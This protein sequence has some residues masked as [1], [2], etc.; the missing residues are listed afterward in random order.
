M[1]LKMRVIRSPRRKTSQLTMEP[2]GVLTVRVPSWMPDEEVRRLVAKNRQ[3]I[4]EKQAEVAKKRD[5]QIRITDQM[6]RDGVEKAL[7]II[8]ERVAFYARQMG[9]EGRYHR[10][11]IREQKTRWG[12]CSSQGNLN[13]N[14]KLVLMPQEVLDYV[15]VHEL[16]HLYEMNHSPRFWSVVERVL[17][18]YKRRRDLLGQWGTRLQ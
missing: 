14:W 7:K 15:V 13:F 11:T 6:R 17:P 4:E 12:S 16:A 5:T 2:D 8:P 3:W 10:I 9:C 1:E 18:D